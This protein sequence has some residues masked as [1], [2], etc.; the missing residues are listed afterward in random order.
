MISNDLQALDPN[1]SDTKKRSPLASQ[2]GKN[3]LRWLSRYV[4]REQLG[5]AV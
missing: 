4:S 2:E 3:G 1:Q 5:W